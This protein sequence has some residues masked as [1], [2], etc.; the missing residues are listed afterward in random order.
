MA[1]LEV[2]RLR[3]L[4]GSALRLRAVA[5]ALT[6]NKRIAGGDRGN[7]G[8]LLNQ[9]RLAAWRVARIA[10]GWLRAHPYVRYQRDATLGTVLANSL[11]AAVTSLSATSRQRAVC[12][13]GARVRAVLR[14]IDDARAL[15]RSAALSDNLGRSQ[16]EF[17][18][19]LEAL[20][21]E[22]KVTTPNPRASRPI[23]NEGSPFLTI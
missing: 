1:D 13:F 17:R 9:G 4:R 3:R 10:S 7:D 15:T 19:V 12:Q 20:E 22:T 16:D 6:D 21:Y 5:R 2:E 14:E 11:V 23:S 8:D 18:A